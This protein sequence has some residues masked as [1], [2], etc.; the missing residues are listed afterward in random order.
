[1]DLNVPV[2]ATGVRILRAS[3]D[4][5]SWVH[6]NTRKKNTRQ[7]TKWRGTA[8]FLIIV[9]FP[10]FW[11]I[12]GWNALILWTPS[13]VVPLVYCRILTILHIYLRQSV[14]KID[15]QPRRRSILNSL[16]LQ[17]VLRRTNLAYRMHLFGGLFQ[18]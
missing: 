9:E 14:P 11:K 5:G 16:G 7:E 15:C 3:D 1:M 10:D 17:R 6:T 18:T 4:I 13:T 12:N 2:F 8:K